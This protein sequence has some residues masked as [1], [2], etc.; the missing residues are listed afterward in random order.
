[1]QEARALEGGAEVDGAEEHDDQV[2]RPQGVC[3]V[4]RLD[5]VGI[6]EDARRAEPQHAER[7]HRA[8]VQAD[9]SCRVVDWRNGEEHAQHNHDTHRCMRHREEAVGASFKHKDEGNAER[10]APKCLWL[11]LQAR[12]MHARGQN[13][14]ADHD[15]QPMN[16]L[17]SAADS[18]CSRHRRSYC[19]SL[20]GGEA[21]SQ[22]QVGES[23]LL[24]E[25]GSTGFLLWRSVYVV[26]QV[27]PRT[28]FLVLFD[29]LKTKLFGRDVTR[30]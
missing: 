20:G 9:R 27:S 21:L 26:K 1:M 28:R 3:A 10:T 17:A 11:I 29:W 8:H 4:E 12:P 30:W 13:A 16:T 6:L 19:R 18:R 24:S 2:V 22:V 25:A 23:R 15:T 14:E 7:R 5:E